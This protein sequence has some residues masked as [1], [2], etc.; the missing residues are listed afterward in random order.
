MLTKQKL[1][2]RAIAS[3][4]IVAF[5]AQE[6]AQAAGSISTALPSQAPLQSL[7]EDPAR[8]E[9]PFDF[10]TLQEIHKGTNGKLI[11]HIQDA[12]TNLSGQQNLAAS[13]DALMTK[14]KISLVLSEGGVNDCSL[15]EIKKQAS[16]AVWKRV[17]K[18][19]LNEGKIAGE[20][21]LNLVSD[22]PMKIMGI[23][24]SDLYWKSVRQYAQLAEKREATLA[25]LRETRR[26]L[27]KLKGKMYPKPL[28][29]QDRIAG[30]DEAGF[31][32]AFKGLLSLA[33]RYGVP[34][35]EFLNLQMLK[36]LQAEES[37]IDFKAA[38][39]EQAAL[40]EAIGKRGGR[41]DL[42]QFVRKAGNI[43]KNKV[44]QLGY[45]QSLFE[46]AKAKDIDTAAY[47]NLLRFGRYLK[48]F[49]EIDLGQ[50]L[51][52][53][54]LAEDRVYLAA[55]ADHPDARL[56][57]AIDRYVGLLEKAY[58]IQMTTRDFEQFV[59]NEPDFVTTAY[60]AFINR[61]LS[62]Q[63]YFG[64]LL[65]YNGVLEA[66]KSAL[67]A[68]YA[69]VDERD[70]VFL[71]NAARHLEENGQNAAFLIAGGYHTAHLKRLFAEEGYSFLVL[72]PIVTGETNQ[73]K[74]ENV[75]MESFQPAPKTVQVSS[76]EGG[77]AGRAPLSDLE[78]SVRARKAD[79]EIRPEALHSDG[80]TGA[81]LTAMLGDV[82]VLSA[83]APQAVTPA[84]AV[85]KKP[86]G[87]RVAGTRIHQ[88]SPALFALSGMAAF[89]SAFAYTASYYGGT[90]VYAAVYTHFAVGM[91]LISLAAWL[92]GYFL[93][94]ADIKAL[95]WG[96]GVPS[97]MA[98]TPVVIAYTGMAITALF[99]GA[100]LSQ[101]TLNSGRDLRA[102][103][104]SGAIKI[105]QRVLDWLGGLIDPLFRPSW[106]GSSLKP[107]AISGPAKKPAEPARE[108]VRAPAWARVVVT[109]LTLILVVTIALA[110][111][112]DLIVQNDYGLFSGPLSW[113]S[114]WMNNHAG[115]LFG[116][117][118]AAYA[119]RILVGPNN[120]SWSVF[121]SRA[122]LV[123]GLFG[124]IMFNIEIGLQN[125]WTDYYVELVGALLFILMEAVLYG[126]EGRYPGIR[127]TGDNIA[128]HVLFALTFPAIYMLS[129]LL[130]TASGWM[131]A[132][133]AGTI[134]LFVIF[135]AV[136]LARLWTSFR[137]RGGALSAPA[138]ARMATVREVAYDAYPYVPQRDEK[139]LRKKF[140]GIF[141]E[142]FIARI[143][144]AINESEAVKSGR[145]SRR[146]LLR[147]VSE[148][149]STTGILSQSTPAL[150]SILVLGGL[151]YYLVFV[152][153]GLYAWLAVPVVLAIAA[154]AWFTVSVFHSALRADKE[155]F[156]LAKDTGFLA[157]SFLPLATLTGLIVLALGLWAVAPLLAL[158]FYIFVRDDGAGRGWHTYSG[159][160]G[161]AS[162]IARASFVTMAVGT[163]V[164][165]AFGWFAIGWAPIAIAGLLMLATF[166]FGQLNSGPVWD[167]L[168]RW[169]DGDMDSGVVATMDSYL[170]HEGTKPT[171]RFLIASVAATSLAATAVFLSAF[172]AASLVAAALAALKVAVVVGVAAFVAYL[173]AMVIAW[174]G[175]ELIP[176][177]PQP[178]V[179]L[180]VLSALFI[181]LAAYFGSLV[182][183][184]LVAVLTVVS[185]VYLTFFFLVSRD[186]LESPQWMV[187]GVGALSLAAAAW[188]ALVTLPMVQALIV[189]GLAVVALTASG[190]AV[191]ADREDREAAE[192]ERRR[193]AQQ[194]AGARL[195]ET[196][197]VYYEGTIG[198][199]VYSM[200]VPVE[201]ISRGSRE[202]MR[203]IDK[204][205]GFSV[206][207]YPLKVF[208]ADGTLVP[209]RPA[210][211]RLA[212]GYDPSDER[213]RGAVLRGFWRYIPARYRDRVMEDIDSAAKAHSSRNGGVYP[214]QSVVLSFVSRSY[215]GQSLLLNLA[216]PIATLLGVGALGYMSL[217]SG[218]AAGLAATIAAVLAVVWLI[219]SIGFYSRGA[220]WYKEAIDKQIGGLQVGARLVSWQGIS[221][222]SIS[223]LAAWAVHSLVYNPAAPIP[224]VLPTLAAALT[225][226]II[227]VVISAFLLSSRQGADREQGEIPVANDNEMNGARLAGAPGQV[228]RPALSKIMD[229]GVMFL[230]MFLVA[231]SVI[232]LDSYLVSLTATPGSLLNLPDLAP[233]WN[234]I[235]DPV[236]GSSWIVGLA[237]GMLSGDATMYLF[238]IAVI[239][240]ILFIPWSATAYAGY[241]RSIAIALGL[242]VGGAVTSALVPYYVLAG[243]EL[244]GTVFT[245]IQIGFLDEFGLPF[246]AISLNLSLVSMYI[247]LLIIAAFAVLGD[248]KKSGWSTSRAWRGGAALTLFAALIAVNIIFQGSLI[249]GASINGF[250]LLVIA[251]IRSD[252]WVLPAALIALPIFSSAS[253]GRRI[254]QPSLVEETVAEQYPR[255]IEDAR[256]GDSEAAELLGRYF[257]YMPSGMQKDALKV[258]MDLAD[259]Q[260][261]GPAT[262]ALGFILQSQVLEPREADAVFK[263]ILKVA[264]ADNP[265]A[266]SALGAAFPG[267]NKGQRG[268]A[269][270]RLVAG[271]EKRIPEAIRAR[272][273]AYGYVS[274]KE[275][276]STE[277]FLW[278]LVEDAGTPQAV[279]DE[280]LRAL[281]EI[282]LVHEDPAMVA[283]IVERILDEADRG[284]EGAV[285]AAGLLFEAD[286]DQ[287]RLSDE[288]A[289]RL[290]ETLI[291]LAGND[292]TPKS[293]RRKAY[294][295]LGRAYPS[296]RARIESRFHG[297]P[298]S[299][300][301]RAKQVLLRGFKDGN[302]GAIQGVGRAFHALD[303]GTQRALY[304][305]IRRRV[306][307]GNKNAAL[308]LLSAL[309]ATR[310][311]KAG[312]YSS[313]LDR[314][315]PGH[316]RF[317]AGFES[318]FQS[319][320]DK[321][322]EG[323]PVALQAVWEALPILKKPAQR[324]E[325]LEVILEQAKKQTAGSKAIL[326]KALHLFRGT[327]QYGVGYA[328][329]ITNA[330]RGDAD[331]V[332]GLIHH[333]PNMTPEEQNT[334]LPI[335]LDAFSADNRGAIAGIAQMLTYLDEK[336][337]DRVLDRL[338]KLTEHK[339][340]QVREAAYAALGEI[341][342]SLGPR[343]RNV[344]AALRKG[345]EAGSETAALALALFHNDK[346]EKDSVRR[347]ILNLLKTQASKGNK[348]AAE[349]LGLILAHPDTPKSK[350]NKIIDL[351]V[352]INSPESRAA[353]ATA[354]AQIK[355][356]GRKKAVLAFLNPGS[357]PIT[358]T[359]A[360]GYIRLLVR[361]DQ[362][363][364]G[365]I[366]E[367]ELYDLLIRSVSRIY[368]NPPSLS[369]STAPAR[370]SDLTAPIS[371]ADWLIIEANFKALTS[372]G[373]LKIENESPQPAA[374][375]RLAA[376]TLQAGQAEVDAQKDL[377]LLKSSVL[378]KTAGSRL[379]ASATAAKLVGLEPPADTAFLRAGTEEP[380]QTRVRGGRMADLL[381]AISDPELSESIGQPADVLLAQASEP[382][383]FRGQL[384]GSQLFGQRIEG[385]RLASRP[386][387]ASSASLA[388]F[389]QNKLTYDELQRIGDLVDND[390]RLLGMLAASAKDLQ[391]GAEYPLQLGEVVAVIVFGRP[392]EIS[393]YRSPQNGVRGGFIGIVTLNEEQLAQ[394]RAD[395]KA[396][397]G[398]KLDE[399]VGA[400]GRL[401]PEFAQ[402]AAEQARLLRL[403]GT[404]AA[405]LAQVEAPVVIDI[406]AD[407]LFSSESAQ[408]IVDMVV[409][410]K[411][412]LAGRNIFVRFINSDGSLNEQYKSLSDTRPITEGDGRVL[413]AG[414]DSLSTMDV[415]AGS[416]L[417][418]LPDVSKGG[419]IPILLTLVTAADVKRGGKNS[420]VEQELRKLV[421]DPLVDITE[422]AVQALREIP[423][424]FSN[425]AARARYMEIFYRPFSIRVMKLDIDNLVAFTQLMTAQVGRSA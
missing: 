423:A 16:P 152:A 219:Y 110:L 138:G 181:G 77:S 164:G 292:K 105:I 130:A 33:D 9:T 92:L 89:I 389:Y 150:L 416:G 114:V 335:I 20:E 392:N 60:L 209:V 54:E 196:K 299:I 258:L 22:H 91:V 124:L 341:R 75:L 385:A 370:F 365:I 308:A 302:P 146:D 323:D 220:S 47:P 194:T 378:P 321:A 166:F 44:S 247:G 66:G 402:E 108:T 343:R 52:E 360:R 289:R 163:L 187:G 420:V 185:G 78:M 374:A 214:P 131:F 240:L 207:R 300:L 118:A 284:S 306:E 160:G 339:D 369:Q 12:H 395:V 141:D 72:T 213:L 312:G 348:G 262:L 165:P 115:D 56:V 202:V 405:R 179:V 203:Y 137:A 244:A 352:R 6:T 261:N 317:R 198:S 222:L 140:S 180:G 225:F 24:E 280:A 67:T 218:F 234:A 380:I 10:S 50:A 107:G 268:Q 320:L 35:D 2:I 31:E 235:Q 295:S 325:A 337:K 253:S 43:K 294:D 349:G 326:G 309:S 301:S 229:F 109:S 167:D 272:G 121:I 200:E 355:D 425:S 331:A 246:V 37:E 99:A 249:T 305:D 245:Y 102:G 243:T 28:L 296:I 223:G 344:L 394:G 151:A 212:R 316:G 182:S 413:L 358:P 256:K 231:A 226:I 368:L 239:A 351:L 217:L 310:R 83:R 25:Y 388:L 191:F 359:E 19:Y 49:S 123:M 329:L 338:L 271:S 175:D 407:D 205:N 409:Q 119:V 153:A 21:Y 39:L 159:Y 307:E 201:V 293:L 61:K 93:N 346:N 397:R 8:F 291:H 27:E 178:E 276:E 319:L 330:R 162:L 270:P 384:R 117:V 278:Q 176:G 376:S 32:K 364:N 101:T 126:L 363:L 424:D 421:E 41:E 168:R 71:R 216:L 172:T 127:Q 104:G 184:P 63:G 251:I 206:D 210:G 318:A 193:W 367:E 303:A 324:Q 111:G 361:V 103:I 259:K 23:E 282:A 173:T 237:Q 332:L 353:L 204:Q 288:Q 11:I 313:R 51:V 371:P 265:F 113:V 144:A 112:W 260:G 400:S 286:P 227:L 120:Q 199:T 232:G 322:R 169:A 188:L 156:D 275:Q 13:L 406:V 128:T 391:S 85:V 14:Y 129:A 147:F 411:A 277:A 228:A 375:A 145:V 342:N 76:A 154:V 90:S 84:E 357:G 45:F 208:F 290:I 132:L 230:A 379:R 340:P 171:N 96:M 122:V 125:D 148:K 64:D 190:L 135:I 55:L 15:T 26:A 69:S 136:Y 46:M 57:R 106:S 336:T 381:V 73:K 155:A 79:S 287:V 281:G 224:W 161:L 377:A 100:R 304:P 82:R 241:G 263:I 65:P 297:W 149:Y 267:L 354:Y 30:A 242:V 311:Q 18:Q 116:A 42:E 74:Y 274:A 29:E 350:Q 233:G 97:A 195:T 347:G 285:Y 95:G 417:F 345:A 3:F 408:A 133:I 419:G 34:L 422:A 382:V 373:I 412:Y 197:T 334:V 254:V 170:R 255:W 396:L 59:L 215:S 398:L 387:T 1:I 264:D 250:L 401:T 266:Y 183:I 88:D 192:R 236:F 403:S 418:L 134:A 328:L 390:M 279:R 174:L 38:N 314:D 211:A 5:L 327:F 86:A 17:A 386:V 404:A 283:R 315:V 393:F 415:P 186:R 399:V 58:R 252:G 362:M 4:L 356:G 7:L 94:N 62:E 177:E 139:T 372:G 248:L 68:F 383:P 273:L 189:V 70:K 410:A 414:E 142:A 221:A 40:V 53:M 87:A 143:V 366:K 298:R 48:E 257:K 158:A 269:Y 98:V 81:R 238:G 36:A 80:K 157:A 333:F